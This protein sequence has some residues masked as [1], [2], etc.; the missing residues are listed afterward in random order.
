[1]EEEGV[2][3]SGVKYVWMRG[4]KERMDLYGGIMEMRK[5]REEV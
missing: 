5:E 1:L 2:R 3:G 4:K